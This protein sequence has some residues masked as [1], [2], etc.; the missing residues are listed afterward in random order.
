M[1]HRCTIDKRYVRRGIEVCEEWEDYDAF[2]KWA[3]PHLRMFHFMYPQGT[4]PAIDRL[5][6]NWHYEP[7]NCWFISK[8]DNL[9]KG[10]MPLKEYING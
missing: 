10:S 6:N 9:K 3:L 1:K 5:N 2:R 7:R 8:Q 4:R